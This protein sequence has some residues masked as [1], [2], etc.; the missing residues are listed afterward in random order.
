M[1]AIGK[2]ETCCIF[3]RGE[4]CRSD[5]DIQRNINVTRASNFSS[6]N[7]SSSLRITAE[8]VVICHGTFIVVNDHRLYSR[9][10]L[11]FHYNASRNAMKPEVNKV[12]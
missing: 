8:T 1:S 6:P 7:D 2:C 10:L 11:L 3:R 5:R 4:S 9:S 12:Y